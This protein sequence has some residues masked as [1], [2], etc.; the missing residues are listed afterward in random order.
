MMEIYSPD[1]G[2]VV[3]QLIL[4]VLRAVIGPIPGLEALMLAV[5]V[6]L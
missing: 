2:V 6:G 1:L 3:L 5:L 4:L